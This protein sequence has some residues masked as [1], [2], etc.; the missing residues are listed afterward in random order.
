M[1]YVI[2]AVLS[3][4][5]IPENGVATIPFPLSRAEYDHSISGVL[6]PMGIGSAVARD[7]MVD[8]ID[9]GYHL[10]GTGAAIGGTGKTAEQFASGEVAY[11]L[12]GSQGTQVWGQAL[13]G[14]KD[15]YPVLTSAA[16]KRVW[17][18]IFQVDEKEHAT[19]YANNNGTAI[20]P[21]APTAATGYSFAKWSQTN[22][23]DG[24]EFNAATKV[25]QDMTVYAVW[26]ANQYTVT[27][28]ANDGSVS[29]ASKSVTYD[30]TYGDLPTPTRA[31]PLR[32]G[33]QR[34]A[35]ALR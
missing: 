17:R 12:Q 33:I 2:K 19:R 24:A 25:T 18:V 30:G 21:T 3:N 4:P 22:A 32:A 11:L 10:E 16:D 29:T 34:P 23:A 27:F 6:E 31:I 9:S 7:C 26:S 1:S 28:N 35:A 5:S 8:D 15:A 20:L 13:Q 14:I